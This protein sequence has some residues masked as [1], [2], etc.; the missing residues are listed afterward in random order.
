MSRQN[1]NKKVIAKRV[2][3]TSLHKKAVA[4]TGLKRTKQP[5]QG[6]AVVGFTKKLTSKNKGLCTTIKDPVKG[7]IRVSASTSHKVNAE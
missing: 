1:K 6:R 2:Q 4:T 7:R 3:V 5:S